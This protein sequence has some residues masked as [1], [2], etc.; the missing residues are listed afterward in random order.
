MNNTMN[1]TTIN[2]NALLSYLTTLQ[3]MYSKMFES[4]ITKTNIKDSIKAKE[5]LYIVNTLIEIISNDLLPE[6]L[7]EN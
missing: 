2:K 4:A 1:N 5:R 3:K 7:Y 6:S